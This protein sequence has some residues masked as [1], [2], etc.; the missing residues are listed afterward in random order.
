MLV[1]FYVT[2][3]RRQDIVTFVREILSRFHDN[4]SLAI[5]E[6]PFFRIAGRYIKHGLSRLYEKVILVTFTG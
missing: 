4:I 2:L 3:L 6:I 5:S 1:L